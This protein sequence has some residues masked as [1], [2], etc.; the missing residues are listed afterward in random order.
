MS[1]SGDGISKTSRLESSCDFTAGLD[2]LGAALVADLRFFWY[3]SVQRFLSLLARAGV[4]FLRE[5]VFHS[6]MQTKLH[7]HNILLKSSARS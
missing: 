3:H 1:C 6:G 4:F 5:E 7:F 2:G